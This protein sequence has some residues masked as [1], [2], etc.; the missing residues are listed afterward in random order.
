MKRPAILM[1]D[2]TADDC[3]RTFLGE[4]IKSAV[5]RLYSSALVGGSRHRT[6]ACSLGMPEDRIFLG[7]DAVDNGYFEE[8]AKAARSNS[9]DAERALG[10][11][12]GPYF[13]AS[14]RFIEKKNLFGLLDAFARYRAR[15]PVRGWSMVILGDGELRASLEARRAE[16]NLVPDVHFPGFKQYDQLPMWYGRSSC[17]VHASTTEQWG[18]VVNEAMAAGLPVLVSRRCG[19]VP[20]L[21]EEG[22]NGFSYDPHDTESLA[23]LMFSI[24]HGDADREAMGRASQRIIANW[25]PERFAS[26][27]VQA[28]QAALAAPLP[29]PT[30]LDR[31][32]LRALIYR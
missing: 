2:S 20:D 16:L 21:V 15:V 23:Q 8:G 24:A 29:Q 3:R 5:V 28:V 4:R 11:P 9:A 6:Y 31:A 32:L 19:C 22:V 14:S 27:L 25:G 12:A 10:I 26:G 7:Y 17:F 30:I 18:L 13:L 1:S